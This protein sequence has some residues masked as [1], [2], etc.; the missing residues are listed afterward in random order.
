MTAVGAG[1]TSGVR[2]LDPAPGASGSSGAGR[3]RRGSTRGAV[4]RWVVWAL[5]A[6]GALVMFFPVYW[7]FVTAISPGG[8]SQGSGFSLWPK[9][10]DLSVFARVFE[11]QPIGTW[12]LNSTIISVASVLISVSISLLAGYA[13]AKYRFR[14][15][16]AL[17]ALMLLTIMVPIQVIVVPEFVIISKLGLVN[18]YWSVILP[19]A[20]QGI[21]IFIAR[22]FLVAL[23]DELIEAARVD[24][25][26]ELRIFLRVVLPMS[27]PLIAVLTILTFVWRWN[28]FIW[29]LVTLQTSNRFTMSVGLNS[30]N[31]AYSHPWDQ[32]MAVTLLSMIPVIIVFLIFQRQFVQGIAESGLK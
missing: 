32:I 20:A 21:C 4:G 30:L 14:G 25:A 22:Q 5:L 12:M 28:D 6:L 13:F 15:R 18:S 24:G 29:P 8:L 1:K 27:G 10:F 7:V 3:R 16:N 26:S 17:F 11:D 9:H 19:S 23:P 31:G 2:V